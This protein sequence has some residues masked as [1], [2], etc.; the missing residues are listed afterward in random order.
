MMNTVELQS[1]RQG[2]KVQS[3]I[4]QFG[5]KNWLIRAKAAISLGRLAA[6]TAVYRLIDALSDENYLVRFHAA[7]ALK[8]IGT[9]K[10]VKAAT[11]WEQDN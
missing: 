2:R 5:D 6:P 3:L 11:V 9:P 7:E 4:R 1:K 10:A 8:Q